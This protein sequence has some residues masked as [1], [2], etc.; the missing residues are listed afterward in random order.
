MHNVLTFCDDPA[1][2]T[3]ESKYCVSLLSVNLNNYS[4]INEDFALSAVVSS[5]VVYFLRNCNTQYFVSIGRNEA[6]YFLLCETISCELWDKWLVLDDIILRS[7][8]F[9]SLAWNYKHS[10]IISIRTIST[11]VQIRAFCISSFRSILE[12]NNTPRV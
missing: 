4:E 3:S 12:I 6:R 2:N 1:I 11:T 5:V 8:S 7:M 10:S 9:S